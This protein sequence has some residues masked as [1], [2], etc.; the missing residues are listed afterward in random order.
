MTIDERHL[1]YSRMIFVR[2][3]SVFLTCAALLSPALAEKYAGE[4]LYLGAGARPLAMG[5]AYSAARGDI[6]SGYYN[7]AGLAVI[8]SYQ[9][10]FMHS[11]TFGSLLN[12]DFLAI[13]KR[14]AGGVAALSLYRL[15][16]GG[17]LVTEYVD[18]LDKFRVIREASHADYIA[19]FSYA[20]SQTERINWGLTAKLVYRKIID[21]SAWGIGLDAGVRYQLWEEIAAAFSVQDLTGTV[22]S[23]ST[24][25]KETINP[26]AKFGL[27]FGHS[28]GDFRS[29]ILADADVRFEGRVESAQF[30]QSWISTDTHFGFELSYKDVIA[31]RVGSDVGNLT[32]GV[33]VKFSRYTLDLALFDHSD[34]DTSYRGSLIIAW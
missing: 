16:G 8:D 3:L 31:A 4:F 14:H 6:F 9:A 26:T 11:E 13:A 30:S 23:Y 25:T 33:G 17:I 10:A 29:L 7:P 1:S 22:L 2:T 27:A 28:Y 20:R 5:G 34:L 12:H 19:G 18:Y 21:S 24:D 15:G 32:T